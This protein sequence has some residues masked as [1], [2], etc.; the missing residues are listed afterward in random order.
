MATKSLKVDNNSRIVEILGAQAEPLQSLRELVQNSIEAGAKNIQVGLY[1]PYYTDKGLK[2]LAVWDDGRGMTAEELVKN[3]NSLAVDNEK[4]QGLG[5]NFGIGSKVACL[6]RNPFGVHYFSWTKDSQEG[7]HIIAYRDENGVYGL[8]E[9]EGQHV[10]GVSDNLKP[11]IIGESGTCVVL[12]GEDELSDTYAPWDEKFKDK[13]RWQ[14]QYLNHRYTSLPNDVTVRTALP[15]HLLL[16][17]D[18]DIEK[19]LSIRPATAVGYDQ[20]ILENASLDFGIEEFDNFRV[21]WF[22][23]NRTKEKL[24]KRYLVNYLNTDKPN[25][26]VRYRNERYEVLHSPACYRYF[27]AFGLTAGHSQI[28]IHVEP[29][30]ALLQPDGQRRSFMYKG[31][32]ITFETWLEWGEQFKQNMPEALTEFLKK[33][34]AKERLEDT[35]ELEKQ[36]QEIIRSFQAFEAVI[37]H[38]E[39]DASNDGAEDH[40]RDG[41]IGSTGVKSK[42]GNEATGQKPSRL[43]IPGS[44]KPGKKVLSQL[45]IPT[46]SWT[47]PEA[48]ERLESRMAYYDMYNNHLKLNE[49]HVYLSFLHEQV[50]KK[51]DEKSPAI[52]EDTKTEMANELVKRIITFKL[53]ARKLEDGHSD[54]FEK[55]FDQLSLEFSVC[56]L[57][58]QVK[59]I[60]ANVKANTKYRL[61]SADQEAAE[62]SMSASAI[63]V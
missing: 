57:E 48:E 3:I 41:K 22:I 42:I 52:I 29:K 43:L 39:G 1:V 45:D 9:D 62:E 46:V 51:V 33:E 53:H 19:D 6:Y 28:V 18:G 13:V 31:E 5:G 40:H 7:Q 63:E 4:A 14:V 17:F 56:N 23:T 50:T 27:E 59:N 15:S 35:K 32:P 49:E 16:N 55:G 2:K 20:V 37:K 36:I 34:L 11:D 26:A 38:S 60:V 30:E 12:M 8:Y 10:W 25:V 58:T 47:T 44:S 24:K 54:L 61:A 21:Y